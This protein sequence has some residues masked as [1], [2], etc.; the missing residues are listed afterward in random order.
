[1]NQIPKWRGRD[2]VFNNTGHPSRQIVPTFAARSS[3]V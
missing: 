2:K 3:G 1:M